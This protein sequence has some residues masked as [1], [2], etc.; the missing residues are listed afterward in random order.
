MS[1]RS[2][3][4]GNYAIKF[5]YISLRH[6]RSKHRIPSLNTD[7]NDSTLLIFQNA[8]S[9]RQV[10]AGVFDKVTLIVTNEIETPHQALLT[11][12]ASQNANKLRARRSC[13][14]HSAAS[15]TNWNGS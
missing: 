6:I 5:F 7:R 14:E 3:V 11:C 12:P 2:T 10:F 8:G 4:V 13:S 15:R 9:G 1:C